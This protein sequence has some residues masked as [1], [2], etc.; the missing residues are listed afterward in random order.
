VPESIPDGPR[1]HAPVL[2]VSDDVFLLPRLEDAA[3]AAALSPVV[4]DSPAALGAEGDP[5][6]RRTPITEPLEGS[7]AAFLQAVVDDLPAL[8][9]FDLASSAL[10]WARWIQVL[11]TSSAARRIPVLAFG[12]HVEAAALEQARS[13]GADRVVTRGQL[14]ARLPEILRDAARVVDPA[15]I[16]AGCGQPAAPQA[17]LGIAALLSGRYFEAHE[18]LERA[19]LDDPGVDSGVYRALLHLAVACLHV[20]RGNWP[21][22]QK[23]LLRMRPWLAPLAPR[24]RGVNVTTLRAALETLQAQLDGWRGGGDPPPA[25]FPPPRVEFAFAPPTSVDDAG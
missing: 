9:V 14:Q 1:P 11:K 2:L 12:P 7:D 17:R 16:R 8:I 18:H 13:L 25:P 4:V 15:V 19:I 24:C 20:E 5:L 22:A 10:P 3:R 23:M 21:G 6:P